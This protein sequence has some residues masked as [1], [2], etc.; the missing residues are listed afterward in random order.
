MFV[1]SGRIRP[2]RHV[3]LTT[4]F[5]AQGLQ[6]GALFCLGIIPCDDQMK[7]RSPPEQL[8]QCK[9]K[10]PKITL[11]GLGQTAKIKG[12]AVG[13]FNVQPL[14]EDSAAFRFRDW[15]IHSQR[16]KNTARRIFCTRR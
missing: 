9:D 6:A 10:R 1:F 14:A 5:I 8:R 2:N 13:A 7:F 4:Q 16:N 15:N 11:A 3:F 12:N